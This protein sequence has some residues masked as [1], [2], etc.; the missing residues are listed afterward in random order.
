[1]YSMLIIK[2]GTL[3]DGLRDHPTHNQALFIADGRIVEIL[4]LEQTCLPPDAEIVDWRAGCV[5]PGLI[6]CHVHLA[7][8]GAAD[9]RQFKDDPAAALALR[10]AANAKKTLKAGFT[11]V[12]NLGSN[13]DVDIQLKKAI[14]ENILQGPEIVASGRCLAI[15]GGHGHEGGIEADGPWAVRKAV[16]TL[17][18]KGADVIKIM[19]TGGVLTEGVEP[20]AA[21][22]SL[23]EL[24][25]AAEEAHRAGRKI[26]THAHGNI[27]IRNAVAA[28]ID[29][30]EHGV[31][32]DEETIALMLEK[33]TALVPTLS[34]P[35]KINAH[36]RQSGI[37]EY[38]VAKNAKIFANHAK[39]FR[40]AWEAGVTIGLGTDAGTPL[41]YHGE[42]A[43]ELKLMVEAGMQPMAALKAATSNAAEILGLAGEVGQLTA[44]ARADFLLLKGN[45]L[46]DI[47]L[48]TAAQNIAA[49]YRSGKKV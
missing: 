27:G 25:A 12:R 47:G 49:V 46:E 10:A 38:A 24:S 2:A 5:L 7:S 41:N 17:L 48:L 14:N 18:K 33:G 45:P 23:E 26:A 13:F 40:L 44:G 1:V 4:P 31:F 22:F 42:N 35:H 37:P 32:L 16:R 15:T 43:G 8:L 34:A 30:I 6:D 20:G 9:A 29:T 11:T 19:A 28:G 36:G 21:E 39:S 3:I